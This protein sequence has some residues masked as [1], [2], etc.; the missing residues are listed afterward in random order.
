MR[1]ELPRGALLVRVARYC[2][3]AVPVSAALVALLLG[4]NASAVILSQDYFVSNGGDPARLDETIFDVMAPLRRQ[5]MAPQ[6]APVVLQQNSTGIC[7]ATWLGDSADGTKSYFLTARHCLGDEDDQAVNEHDVRLMHDLLELDPASDQETWTREVV[8]GGTGQI[9][10]VLPQQVG[11]P[12]NRFTD[13]AILET[14]K[15]KDMTAPD[16]SLVAKPRI[17]IGSNEGGKPITFVGY[18]RWGV[19]ADFADPVLPSGQR[20]G[21]GSTTIRIHPEGGVQGLFNVEGG[22]NPEFWARVGPGDSGSAWWQEQGGVWSIVGTTFGGNPTVSSGP[23]IS[24]YWEWIRSIYPDTLFYDYR[25]AASTDAHTEVFDNLLLQAAAKGSLGTGI[26]NV[27]PQ[28]EL[29][30]VVDHALDGNSLLNEGLVIAKNGKEQRLASLNGQGSLVLEDQSRIV[31]DNPASDTSFYRG[32][33]TGNGSLMK[34]GAGTLTLAGDGSGFSGDITVT[35]SLLN[36]TGQFA[37]ARI[38]VAHEATFAGTGR[39]GDLEVDGT[40]VPGA[41]EGG[42]VLSVAGDVHL[43]P[44]STF[45]TIAP[46]GGELGQLVADGKIRIDGSHMRVTASDINFEEDG[47]YPVMRA[48]RGIEG[49]FISLETTLVLFTP[50]I[51]QELGLL[52]LVMRRSDTSIE[53]LLVAPNAR[54]AAR[55]LEGLDGSHPL[56]SAIL[57]SD[58]A[59]IKAAFNLLPGDIHP[60]LR[61]ILAHHT[62]QVGQTA[63]SRL[64][65]ISQPFWFEPRE[66]CGVRPADEAP[67]AER[68]QLIYQCADGI[69]TAWG[70]GFG[71]VSHFE[72]ARSGASAL[73]HNASGFEV[74][75]DITVASGWR[76]GFSGSYS[77]GSLFSAVPAAA[78]HASWVG[79]LYGAKGYGRLNVGLGY[80]HARHDIRTSRTV[81]IRSFHEQLNSQYGGSSNQIFGEASYDIVSNTMAVT[82][83]AGFSYDGS[84]TDAF[85][86][87]GGEAALAAAKAR[88]SSLSSQL[89]L[90]GAKEIIFDDASVLSLTGSLGWDL[91]M[92]GRSDT[93]QHRFAHSETTFRTD[94]IEL[95]RSALAIEMGVGLTF[96]Q[97]VRFNLDYT[98]SWSAAGSSNAV[99]GMLSAEF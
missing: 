73:S 62:R 36:V 63:R 78:E 47:I 23:R 94:G 42:G 74:G 12:V 72:A 96:A 7:T 13:V 39:V 48:D 26:V 46:D 34:G 80:S 10:H 86:E 44:G 87:G 71:I 9:A 25:D 99:R 32:A 69:I 33:I 76:L 88:G 29:W 58:R 21:M 4:T 3:S 60:S 64:R 56:K 14:A 18:G 89:G 82:P 51:Q 27:A 59:G 16:G 31:L 81:A 98:G 17:Y 55:A 67:A 84:S 83:F 95:P 75:A 35:Q 43:K 66:Q 15:V 70:G 65:G 8:A 40:L 54:A 28:G 6:F 37:E 61:T 1:L 90:R 30:V 24:N 79:S 68:T 52:A 77:S 5:S 50:E 19:G 91:N 41:L 45:H 85:S 11:L 38:A 53:E 49:S 57:N 2:R 92:S 97:D 22:D 93:N 20:R